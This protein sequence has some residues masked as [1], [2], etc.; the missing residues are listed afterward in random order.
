MIGDR[1][2]KRIVRLIK[3]NDAQNEIENRSNMSV[4]HFERSV[5]IDVKMIRR[6]V[7]KNQQEAHQ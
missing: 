7:I 5:T 1:L 4:L 6:T 2:T 3:G